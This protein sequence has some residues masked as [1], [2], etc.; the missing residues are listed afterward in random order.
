MLVFYTENLS[1]RPLTT[2]SQSS[3]LKDRRARLINDGDYSTSYGYCAHTGY[4]YYKA[5]VQ[6]DLGQPYT[7][8]SVKIYYRIEGLSF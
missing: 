3:T 2:V 1:R 6:V 7:I 8:N 4:N 5:W